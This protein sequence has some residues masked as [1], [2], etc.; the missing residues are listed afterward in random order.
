MAATT[1][2]S[3]C[4]TNTESET[5]S[6]VVALLRRPDAYAE[7]TRSVEVIETHISWIFLTDD[8]AYKLKKPVRFDFLDFSTAQLRREACANEVKLN[9]R[10]APGVHPRARRFHRPPPPGGDD[11]DGLPVARGEAARLVSD[12]AGTDLVGGVFLFDG[13][14]EDNSRENNGWGLVSGLQLAF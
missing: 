1:V 12:Q 4:S 9:R 13:E 5:S 10:L 11:Q 3:S 8:F 2:P 14:N 6:R 7:R